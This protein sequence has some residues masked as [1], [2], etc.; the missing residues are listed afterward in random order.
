MGNLTA[1]IV[2]LLS[3]TTNP[4]DYHGW[5]K[6]G[7]KLTTLIP[8]PYSSAVPAETLAG[9]AD[10]TFSVSHAGIKRRLG[11]IELGD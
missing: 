2:R 7:M 11:M 4:H 3:C 9:I 1:P 10:F 6:L 5:V 8:H